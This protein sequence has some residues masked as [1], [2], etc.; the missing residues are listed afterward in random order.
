[1]VRLFKHYVP[2]AVLLLCLFDLALLAGA[3]ELAWRIRAEQ[4]G[5]SLGVVAERSGMLAGFTAIML[6]AMIATGVYDTES[7]RS[8]RY[9]GAR[10]LVAASLGTIALSFAD[11]LI[12]GAIFWRSM[13]TVR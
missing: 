3:A 5:I 1:M 2:H 9:A 6:T 11:W 12:T 4:I 8:L 7:L 13:S 10:L